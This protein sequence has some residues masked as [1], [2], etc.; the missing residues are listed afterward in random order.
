MRIAAAPEIPGLKDVF[1]D[2][3]NNKL[4]PKINTLGDF[5][6][7][8]LNI[9]LYIAIFLTFYYLIWGA[10]AYIMARGDKEGLA[11]ARSRISW[12][13]IGLVVIFSSFLI[14]K[15]AQEV[16]KDVL[17]GGTVF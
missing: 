10:F 11:K 14:A 6:S 4:S 16:F 17:K 7:G 15:F 2:R 12:A 3:L 8:I 9:F 13:L 5:I 1:S